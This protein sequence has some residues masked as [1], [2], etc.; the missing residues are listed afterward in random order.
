LFVIPK[1]KVSEKDLEKVQEMLITNLSKKIGRASAMLNRKSNDETKEKSREN[2]V[3]AEIVD[4]ND[5]CEEITDEENN[6]DYDQELDEKE[7]AEKERIAKEKP[8]RKKQ[9]NKI[10]DKKNAKKPQ[11]MNID[12]IANM[13]LGK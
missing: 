6:Q 5:E 3:D 2:I 12:E 7:R 13:F 11:N 8:A 4:E 9:V 10:P 1:R